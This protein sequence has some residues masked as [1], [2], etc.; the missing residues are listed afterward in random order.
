MNLDD[1]K[2][3]WSTE[4][5]HAD[6]MSDLRLDVI[7]GDVSEIHRVVRLRDFWFLLVLV[8][9]SFGP[10]FIH[11][12]NGD[13]LGWLSQL[14]VLSFVLASAVVA[15][16]LLRARKVTRSDDWTLRS[17]LESE[18]EQLEKQKKLGYSVGSW[19]LAPMLPAIAF[20]SL[21]GYHDR[22]GSYVPD[23]SLSVYYLVCIA[24]YGLTFWLCRREAE[25]SFGPLLAKLRRLH[26]E[27]VE[28]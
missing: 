24:V 4:M 26:R 22:T 5:E 2:A 18:I 19:L 21:G 17:R 20:L 10:V 14:G 13:S 25:S 15:F 1:L 3:E 16:A 6:Q 28:G 23:L 27:L 8:L 9:G 7:K 12:V 11:W